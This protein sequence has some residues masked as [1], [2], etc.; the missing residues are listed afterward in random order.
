MPKIS[1][2][3]PPVKPVDAS[4]AAYTAFL[5]VG[6]LACG[7][8]GTLMNKWQDQQCVQNCQA[9]AKQQH[10]FEQPVWQT[11]IMFVGE[12]LCFAVY[13]IGKL[14]ENWHGGW[15]WTRLTRAVDESAF[16]ENVD[17]ERR[18]LLRG[19]RQ[20]LEAAADLN[21]DDDLDAESY[22]DFDQAPTAV[23]EELLLAEEKR[24]LSGWHQLWLALPAACDI[25]ATTMMNVGLLAVSASVYQML[26]GSVYARF[27]LFYLST[28]I[29][30]KT[31]I[32][33]QRPVDRVPVVRAAED[34]PAAVQGVRHVRRPAR[35]CHRG[36][37]AHLFRGAG[38]GGEHGD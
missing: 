16:I 14:M 18:G 37:I 11:M 12:F 25:T 10:K 6:M 21:D 1:A 34:P 8:V 28:K 26:R 30:T 9:P 5:V 38:G 23:D 19:N 31:T 22:V 33:M 27:N 15:R 29:L 24:P 32:Y 4:R 7:T 20:D 13:G 3:N 35:H 36:R 17:E 2:Q